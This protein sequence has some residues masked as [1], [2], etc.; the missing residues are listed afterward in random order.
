MIKKIAFLFLFI[1]STV[2]AQNTPFEDPYGDMI[3]SVYDID[4]ELIYS[5]IEE[6][7]FEIEDLEFEGVFG[8]EIIDTTS[9]KS[10]ITSYE[11]HIDMPGQFSN[12]FVHNQYFGEIRLIY[13]FG[14][15]QNMKE[16]QAIEWYQGLVEF[17]TNGNEERGWEYLRKVEE[18]VSGLPERATFFN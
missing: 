13:N 4:K 10:S 7:L 18:N 12:E 3:S 15:T 11:N 1:T 8:D 14:P 17:F 5:I 6:I 9:L 16:E 2:Y